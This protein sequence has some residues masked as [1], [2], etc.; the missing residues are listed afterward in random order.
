MK[1]DLLNII[2]YMKYFLVQPNFKNFLILIILMNYFQFQIFY[3][4]YLISLQNYFLLLFV[5]H[6]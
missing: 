1:F 3:L 5:K 4:I 6:Y 2:K